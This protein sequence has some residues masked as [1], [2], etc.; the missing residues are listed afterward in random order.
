MLH[1]VRRQQSRIRINQKETYTRFFMEST[2]SESNLLE[3]ISNTI[4][5]T[6]HI[7]SEKDKNKAFELQRALIKLRRLANKKY[8]NEIMTV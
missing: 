7:V 4:L 2:I 5:S 6:L 1:Q 3:E 8:K